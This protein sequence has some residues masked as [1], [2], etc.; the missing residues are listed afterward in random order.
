MKMFSVASAASVAAAMAAPRSSSIE[1]SVAR[2]R[3]LVAQMTSNEKYGLLQGYGWDGYN[4]ANGNFIGNTYAIQRLGVPSLNLQDGPQGWRTI[5]DRQ[6]DQIISWPCAL[7]VASTWDR[8]RVYQYAQA[9]ARE[10]KTKGANVILGPSV[11]IGRVARNGR[12]AES[13]AGEDPY[14]SAQATIAYVNGLQ[15][16]GIMATMKHFV[17]NN[18]ENNRNFYNSIVD[19]RSLW[20]IYY[21]A[22][23]AAVEN[24]V[25][26]VMCAYNRVAGRYACD[27]P[28]ILKRDLR[29]TMGFKGWVMSDWWATKSTDAANQGL[30]QEQPGN[31]DSWFS[32]DKLARSIN[33]TVIDENTVHVLTPMI[34]LGILEESWCSP[35]N[36]SN[37]LYGVDATTPEH[38][39]LARAIAGESAVLLK[40]DNAVLPLKAG[41]RVAVVGSACNAQ[42]KLYGLNWDEG[43][44]YVVGGSGRVLSSRAT[45]IS[46]GVR[47]QA[48]AGGVVVSESLNNDVN[49][50]VTLAN[51]ADVVLICAGTTSKEDTDRSNLELDQDSFVRDVLA[52]TNTPSVVAMSTPVTPTLTLIPIP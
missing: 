52:R 16:N 38:I 14:F 7:N 21:P 28:E 9:L 42:N 15:E 22:Y 36:C 17:L 34:D 31:F 40:N 27:Q 32:P 37:Q 4:P 13:I 47:A 23:E 24:N 45:S 10:F 33:M 2:A 1:D 29:D 48:G 12:N 44:Y 35:P 51:N 6:I 50:A 11:D 20:E 49:Q 30:D 3:E 25:A 41:T 39:N 19:E 5:D 46:A 43:S 26:A 8:N 18:Q